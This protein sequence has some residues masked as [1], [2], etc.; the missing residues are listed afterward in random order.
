MQQPNF[1]QGRLVY[2]LPAVPRKL[3]WDAIS[4]CPEY[5]AMASWAEVA[6]FSQLHDPGD[7]ELMPSKDDPGNICGA[8]FG[9]VRNSQPVND[10]QK[11]ML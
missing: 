8:A 2:F 5:A 10:Q 6:A 11:N 9:I 3:N 1:A 7:E 4:V